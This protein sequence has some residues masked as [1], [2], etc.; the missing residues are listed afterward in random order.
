[1]AAFLFKIE[2][3]PFKSIADRLA[4]EHPLCTENT[5]FKCYVYSIVQ[6]NST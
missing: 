4:T 2:D 5:S 1:M 6:G 3:L